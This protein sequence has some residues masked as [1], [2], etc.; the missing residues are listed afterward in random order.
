MVN[1]ELEFLRP[2][3]LWGLLPLTLGAWWAWRRSRRTTTSAWERVVDPALAPYVI[4]PERTG[5]RGRG[6]VRWLFAGWALALLA[7]SGPV[8][9]WREVTLHDAPRAQVLV[10][11][12]SRSMLAEDIVPDR[13]TRARYKVRDLLERAG[14]TRTG[15]VAFA[16]RPYVISPLTDDAAT[17]EAFLPSLEP[18]LMPAQGSRPALAIALA[19]ALLER[20]AAPGGHLILITDAEPSEETMAAA[21][22][23]RAAGHRLSVLGVGTSRG[24]PLRDANG[25][26]VRAADGGI[27]VPQLD[28]AALGELA[29]AGGGVA[30]ALSSDGSDV[31]ALAR[32]RTATAPSAREEGNERNAAAGRTGERY[33]TERAPWLLPPLALLAL[34]L[35]RRGVIA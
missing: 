21:A 16:E 20:S 30:V 17:L 29:R 3:W 26:F 27:V 1:G 10:L 34:A 22:A 23:A 13:L 35:F 2:L 19:A 32:V 24:A 9:E 25:Q 5:S 14:G 7:L 12:L 6:V 31:E 4:E 33:W 28:M 11:D 8:W 15:L 18:S